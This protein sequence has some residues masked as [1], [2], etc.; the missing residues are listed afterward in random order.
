MPLLTH[1]VRDF[2]AEQMNAFMD[3][4]GLDALIFTSA[5][6]F[7]FATNFPTDVEPWER[8]IML[9]VPRNG[10]PV[11]FL[12]ELSQNL[13][14][15][16]KEQGRIWIDEVS[17]YAEHPVGQRMPVR[18]HL[19]EVANEIMRSA[20]LAGA[21]VGVDGVP[22][23]LRAAGANLS[24]LIFLPSAEELRS[25]RW[26]K[27]EEEIEVMRAACEL[28]DWLQERYRENI[29]PGRL[30]QELDMQMTS[31]FLE[32]GA[33]RFPGENLEM[34][35]CFTLSGPASA[36]PH[37]NGARCGYRIQ[38]GDVLVNIIVPRL[39]GLVIEN[40]R[41][42]FAGKPS[43]DQR[44]Y[45]EIAREANEAAAHAAVTGQPVKAIDKAALRVFE[46]AGCADLVCHRTGHGM[47]ILGHEFPD[48]MA[49]NER[50]L[51]TNEVYSAEPGIYVYGLG[52]FRL[53]DTVVVGPEPRILTKASRRIE[54]QIVL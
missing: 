22:G 29:R 1:A 43:D 33:L 23:F 50:P 35:E 16:Q 28:S 6:F 32:E 40:E 10:K 27:H 44:R 7:E 17:F 13:F 24:G 41:T 20:G 51:L 15:F 54:D 34:L 9:V 46:R 30:V 14:R 47:G 25:L 3:A 38:E 36:S 8:P 52:G 48:D 31:L 12:N 21:R 42:W 45:Y 11:G 2:R 18:S 4:R 53:D 19:P 37:G 26:V 39:N 49:F 5:H